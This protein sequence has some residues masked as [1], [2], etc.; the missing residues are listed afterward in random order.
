MVLLWCCCG[1]VVVVLLWLC[2][3][4]CV[5]VVVLLWLCCCGCVVVVVLL[6]L[7]CC[8]CVV[9]LW[10]CVVVCVQNCWWVSSRFLGLSPAPPLAGP[11]FPWTAQNFW[12]GV[13][14]CEPRRPSGLWV[15]GAVLLFFPSGFL[16]AFLF[17]FFFSKKAILS[18]FDF[19]TILL[20]FFSFHFCFDLPQVSNCYAS[21]SFIFCLFF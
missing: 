12:V 5:V 11:P 17:F 8:G 7:C 21:D 19:W 20:F 1:C 6:W 4:G 13:I 18:F 2:C 3:C 9:V 10:C 15:L 16:C 14:L